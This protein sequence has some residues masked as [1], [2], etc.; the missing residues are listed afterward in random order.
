MILHIAV[1]GLLVLIVFLNYNNYTVRK[2]IHAQ[3]K[4][5]ILYWLMVFAGVSAVLQSGTASGDWIILS[6]PLSVFMGIQFVNFKAAWFAEALHFFFLIFCLALQFW[7][8]L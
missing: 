6:V 7:A 4:I 2:N 3:K 8:L 1:F 5:D